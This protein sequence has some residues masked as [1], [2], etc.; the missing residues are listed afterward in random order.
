MK[1]SGQAE[2]KWSLQGLI[3]RTALN[4]LI[5]PNEQHSEYTIGQLLQ[6][7]LPAAPKGENP[8]LQVQRMEQIRKVKKLRSQL[9]HSVLM[10]S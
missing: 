1:P 7:R 9:G 5:H 8:H 10:K 3:T 2:I 6:R 4:T